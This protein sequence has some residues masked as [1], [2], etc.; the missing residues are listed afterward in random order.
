VKPKDELN[1][2]WWAVLKSESFL[3]QLPTGTGGTRPRANIDQLM[4]IPIAIPSLEDR[5]KINKELMMVAN[6]Y[7]KQTINLKETL[8]KTGLF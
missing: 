5:K 3:T 6:S 7:W 1:Y 8:E 2:F 4:N